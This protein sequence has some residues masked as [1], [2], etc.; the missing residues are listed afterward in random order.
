MADPLFTN[1][2]API[3]GS[4]NSVQ[5]AR[6]AFRVAKVCGAGVTLLY[7]VDTVVMDELRKFGQEHDQVQAELRE[8]GWRYLDYAAKLAEE[9]GVAVQTELREGE[10]YAEIVS[11]ADS[12][13]AD[14]IVMGHVGRRGPRRILVG[15]VTE[16][17]IEFAH[18]P[19]LVAKAPRP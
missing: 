8:N 2:L 11:L 10:P 17:V 13:G 5:A 6:L 4:E 3:D 1:I 16:R 15:S 14:L 7:V 12:M 19:V 9:A 18:C